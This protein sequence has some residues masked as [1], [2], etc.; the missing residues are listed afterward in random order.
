MRACGDAG[1]QFR[2]SIGLGFRVRD[3]IR[4]SVRDRVCVRVSDGVMV[5]TF[6][7]FIKLAAPRSPHPR[8]A[9]ILPMTMCYP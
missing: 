9:R 4:V 8:Q 3:K 6:Y 7:F 1:L 2:V 5:S